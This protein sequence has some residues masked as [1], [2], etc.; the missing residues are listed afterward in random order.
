M[1]VD[2]ALN[3][4]IDEMVSRGAD[5]HLI[6]V[7]V[8]GGAKMEGSSTKFDMG[9]KNYQAVR[10]ILYKHGVFLG[11]KDVGGDSPRTMYLD[12]EQ[13]TVTIRSVGVEKIL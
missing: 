8:A 1:F 2:T 3:I 12:M 10:K 9:K 6:Q 4:L 5:K 7:K 11:A 13:G